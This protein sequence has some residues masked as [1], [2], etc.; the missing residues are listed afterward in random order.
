[1]P[2]SGVLEASH[3]THMRV[4]TIAPLWINEAPSPLGGPSGLPEGAK[5]GKYPEVAKAEVP[6]KG[7]GQ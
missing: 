2:H 7:K 6:R 3:G 1:V 4:Q 5:P